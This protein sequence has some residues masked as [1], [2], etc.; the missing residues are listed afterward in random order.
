M[1]EIKNA[2]PLAEPYRRKIGR[3]TF[4]VSSFGDPQASETGQQLLLRML[5]QQVTQNEIFGNQEELSA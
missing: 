3:A 5:E 4:Q 2:V 1:S